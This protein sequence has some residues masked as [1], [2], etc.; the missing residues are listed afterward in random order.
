MAERE[1]ANP[2]STTAYW[3]LAARYADATGAKPVAN[4]TYAER[5][6]DD[7]ARAVAER[8]SP[9]KRAFAS[10]PVRHRIVDDL[11]R[12]E[13]ERDPTML[14]VLLGCGFDSRAF[15]LGA[16]RWLEVD[17]PELIAAKE[18]RLPAGEAP[19]ELVRVPIRFRH[20]SL[21]A[22]LTPYAST[23][24]VTIVL[25]G[26]L[27]Y[28]PDN[29]RRSLL[30]TLGRL[31]PRHIVLC[32]LLT[33]TFLARYARGL[34]RFLGEMGLEFAA[35]SDHPEALFHELG[36]STLARVSVPSRAAELGAAG[37]PPAWLV[38]LLPGFRTGYCVWELQR[39]K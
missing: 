10:F 24:T 25:E 28:L 33:R 7:T 29:Q 21:E 18:A 35:S 11:L 9:L 12:A 32:D 1:P 20:E 39:G 22:A 17:E 3:T 36:Y 27:G 30:V 2:V 31:F 13:L 5:F 15:R 19:N 16:G 6:I 14:V 26:V 38:R 4:D 37:A 23:G 8:F 34:V